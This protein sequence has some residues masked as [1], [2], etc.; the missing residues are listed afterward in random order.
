MSRQQALPLA[1]EGVDPD[2][3]ID[4]VPDQARKGAAS[5]AVVLLGFTFFTPTML[6]GAQVGAA[7][8]LS[9]FL[10][11]MVIGSLV[12][13]LYVAVLAVV[14]AST[15]LTTVMLCR[16]TLGERGSK[17]ASLLL[18]LTQVGWYGVGVATL[19][20]LLAQAA[21]WGDTGARITMLVG[22]VVMGATAYAGFRGL[23]WLSATSVPLMF[24]LATWVVF[25]SLE[26][27]G[28]W[29][30]LAAIEPTSSMSVPVAVTII[31]G[32]FVS[33]GTQVS[34]WTRFARSRR[35][36]FVAALLAFLVGNGLMLFFGAVG[37]IAFGEADF[38]LVLYN[39][40]L[41][42]WGVIMLVGNIWTTNDNTAYAFSV[43]GAELTNHP[44]KRP[45]VVGGVAVGA[46]L[47]VTGIYDGLITYLV[48]L[49]ILIPPLGGVLIGDWWRRWRDGVPDRETYQFVAFEWRCLAAYAAGVAAAWSSDQ[50]AIGIPPVIGILVGLGAA[51]VL[52]PRGSR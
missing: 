5:I 9:D 19:G 40:G 26:E 12:L 17:L 51:L 38:V 35:Q 44:S 41:I 39:L 16:Y 30:G 6:V 8:R 45:F 48:W 15:R 13:G 18:G 29:S 31:V 50:L 28:G 33:G 11:V 24:L 22:A 25:R 14:G 7:F 10:A 23:F 1:A 3:P 47:A 34:N 20:N 43:A 2:Y 52:S 49:G 46:L 21:G 37:A 27:V 36:A 4:P 32:T 42:V